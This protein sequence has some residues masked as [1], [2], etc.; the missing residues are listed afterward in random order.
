MILIV[1]TLENLFGV[2]DMS[3]STQF[4]HKYL[5]T[6]VGASMLALC[7]NGTVLAAGKP[8]LV[9][10]INPG[11]SSAPDY[12]TKVGNRLFFNADD[13]VHGRE[14][15]V[16]D[17]TEAGTYMVVDLLA[18]PNGNALS[19]REL[20]GRA[21][22]QA[23]NA[24][25]GLDLWV[26]DGTPEGTLFLVNISDGPWFA[27]MEALGSLLMFRKQVMSANTDLWRTD[28]TP[29]GTVYVKN[30]E[31]NDIGETTGPNLIL[32]GVSPGTAI[33]GFD[34]WKTD[35]TTAGTVLLAD[36]RGCIFLTQFM[37]G[38]AF[39][40]D[41]NDTGNEPWVSDGTVPGTRLL[42][43]IFPGSGWSDPN[44]FAE[45]GGLLYFSAFNPVIGREPWRSDGTEEGTVLLA[46]LNPTGSGGGCEFTNMNGT[47]F[48]RGTHETLGLE[49]WKSDGTPEGTV[50][51]KDIRPGSQGS[52][53][54]NLVTAGGRL[55]FDADDGIHGRELW[56][57]DGT[58]SGTHLVADIKPGLDPGVSISTTIVNVNGILYFVGQGDT[59]AELWAYDSRQDAIPTISSWGFI[60][61]AL[62]FSCAG[63]VVMH[64]QR[65]HCEMGDLSN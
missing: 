38:V 53:P 27:Q 49:L 2:V 61:L 45:I 24:S 31:I 57:S 40:G 64:R 34:L 48:F 62:L 36:L 1:D 25:D 37:D 7:A 41:G 51:V 35:G 15:W 20:G 42:K 18:G 21:F 46:D 11:G 55:Y 33:P 29:Q 32:A 12:L 8:Y 13:G 23:S 9:K 26:S 30:V 59:F 43:D 54:E 65:K 4:P 22:Y 28:G 17:G 39:N 58:E 16:S 6:T 60:S 50:L 47:L 19:I 10:D 5:I 3:R 14:L 63:V 56:I 52:R 44:C